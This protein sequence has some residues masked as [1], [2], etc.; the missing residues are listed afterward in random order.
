MNS[1]LRPHSTTSSSTPNTRAPW[2]AGSSRAVR[3]I[4]ALA[5]VVA[6]LTSP[7][8][9]VAWAGP[10]FVQFSDP[11]PSPGNRFGATV[12][13][14]S[15]GNVVITAPLD[16]AGGPDAGAVYLFNGATGALISTL[17]GSTAD[18]NVGGGGVVALSNGNFV[19]VS[20]G[21]DN[22]VAV[23]AGAV[24]WGTVSLA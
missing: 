23:D 8:T 16:D 12:L 9:R 22:G 4:A 15:T 10:P 7:V 3:R 2:M 11:N 17:K 18:D 5:A 1:G 20:P 6:L 13:P 21:W 19:V 14:L 24:T